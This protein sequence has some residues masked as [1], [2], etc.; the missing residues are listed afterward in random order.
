MNKKYLIGTIVVV[1]VMAV[2]IYNVIDSKSYS[3][4]DKNAFVRSAYAQTNENGVV[5]NTTTT[6]T[7]HLDFCSN[8]AFFYGTV[9]E[10][11]SCTNGNT[12]SCENGSA[13]TTW[14]CNGD[15]SEK[16]DVNNVICQ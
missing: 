15:K 9:T 13:T 2:N 6:G 10:S 7:G 8:S 14:K 11:F 1:A 12:G 3:E 4:V 5:C 16:K